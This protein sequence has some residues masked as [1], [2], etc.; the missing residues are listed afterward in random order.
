MDTSTL[1]WIIVGIVVVVAVVIIIAVVLSR[2]NS[3]KRLEAQHEK[4]QGL[5]EDARKTETA[6]REREAQAAQARADTASA[7]AEAEQAKARAAQASVEA[8]RAAATIDDHASDAAKLRAEQAEKLR[9]ADKIDPAVTTAGSR[10][11]A[12]DR[13]AVQGHEEPVF[14]DGTAA[15]DRRDVVRDQ[16]GDIRTDDRPSAPGRA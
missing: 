8:D 9:E 4:A 7:A 3:A 14:D 16:D 6:A 5:R 11:T 13:R 10:R 12:D 15:R 1:I 2:R